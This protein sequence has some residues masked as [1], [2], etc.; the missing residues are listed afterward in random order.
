MVAIYGG[1][2]L[3]LF[4]ESRSRASVTTCL[5]QFFAPTQCT[6]IDVQVDAIVKMMAIDF[7]RSGSLLLLD[8]HLNG[9][10]VTAWI[11][12]KVTNNGG[13]TGSSGTFD[14]PTYIFL[15]LSSF[16]IIQ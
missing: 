4:Y 5:H 8:I 1:A 14:P 9:S 13:P 15:F 6:Q 12:G 10:L 2:N 16:G 7:D 3:S 11:K